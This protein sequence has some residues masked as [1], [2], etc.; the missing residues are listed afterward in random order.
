M[1]KRSNDSWLPLEYGEL[2]RDIHWILCSSYNAYMNTSY[3]HKKQKWQFLCTKIWH[4]PFKAAIIFI[5]YLL[6]SLISI[7]LSFVYSWDWCWWR[8]NEHAM[9][10]AIKPGCD[11]VLNSPLRWLN[12]MWRNLVVDIQNHSIE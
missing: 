8:S 12:T 4:C 11:R 9:F 1:S 5:W 3:L 2:G 10:T 6:Y 7:S